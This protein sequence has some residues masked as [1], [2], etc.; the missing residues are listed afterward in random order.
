[1]P[2]KTPKKSNTTKKSLKTAEVKV[3]KESEKDEQAETRDFET[4]SIKRCK[5]TDKS[6]DDRNKKRKS[7]A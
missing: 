2:L 4:R 6:E 5:Y 3:N 7:E 1:M